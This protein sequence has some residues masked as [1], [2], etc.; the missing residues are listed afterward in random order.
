MTSL[1]PSEQPVLT[2]ARKS[3]NLA[4]LGRTPSSFF[5]NNGA[6]IEAFKENS[7]ANGNDMKLNPIKSIDRKS[8]YNQVFSKEYS[9][10]RFSRRA[11][12][13]LSNTRRDFIP[14]QN[15]THSPPFRPSN[16]PTKFDIFS[17]PTFKI[18]RA[19]EGRHKL[20]KKLPGIGASYKRFG[21]RLGKEGPGLR[22]SRERIQRVKKIEIEDG[23]EV[24]SEGFGVGKFDERGENES[25]TV[26]LRTIETQGCENRGGNRKM[27]PSV[28]RLMFKVSPKNKIRA[29]LKNYFAE[30]F[31]ANLNTHQLRYTKEQVRREIEKSFNRAITPNS[32]D[33]TPKKKRKSLFQNLG[34]SK[35]IAAAKFK[36]KRKFNYSVEHLQRKKTTNDYG[37]I[38]PKITPGRPKDTRS[39]RDGKISQD[40]DLKS[41]CQKNFIHHSIDRANLNSYV[42]EE[43]KTI[44]KKVGVSSQVG[45]NPMNPLK[46]NQDSFVINEIKSDQ[47]TLHLFGVF[48]GHGIEGLSV[49]SFCKVKISKILK[50]FHAKNLK[51]TEVLKRSVMK[52]ESELKKTSIDCSNSGSTSCFAVVK[53]DMIYFANTGDSRAVLFEFKE[54]AIRVPQEEGKEQ[55]CEKPVSVFSTVDHTPEIS[56]ERERVIDNGGRIS[57]FHGD[58]GP[59]R[60]WLKDENKPGL[61]MTRSIGDYIAKSVGVICDPEIEVQ[62]LIQKHSI[63]VIG[64]DGLFEFLQNREIGE[65]V[66]EHR[67]K[68]ANEV[69]KILVKESVKRWKEKETVIDDCT[70]I[71][72]YI[73]I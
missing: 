52:V 73:T 32:D 7:V 37:Y 41:L 12:Q 21:N 55:T 9:T 69:A 40:S 70:C 23:K 10:K 44:I 13:T 22:C 54:P 49:S 59:L 27:V 47:G 36:A 3:Q 64:S 35:E 50:K 39:S 38:L 46:L 8:S 67:N 26:D 5:R 65:I 71:V 61:A 68:P 58:L 25:K 42:K 63:L 57:K 72:I 48:D 45:Y 4:Q 43:F 18:D 28:G 30:N 62:K 31:E 66:W 33:L 15:T 60:V 56:Q 51:I 17:N 11:L 19:N 24:Q 6:A 14:P 29:K 1:R 16:P 53:D 2:K 34:F 20:N